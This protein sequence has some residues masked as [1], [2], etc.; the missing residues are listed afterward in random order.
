MNVQIQE[1]DKML[2]SNKPASQMNI[3]LSKKR[4][5]ERT[6]IEGRFCQKNNLQQISSSYYL[7]PIIL[8]TNNITIIKNHIISNCTS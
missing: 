6:L 3:W 5:P 8:K 4:K 1:A 7:I 2:L